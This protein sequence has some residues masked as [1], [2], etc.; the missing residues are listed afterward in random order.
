MTKKQLKGLLTRANRWYDWVRVHD[1][2]TLQE[3]KR[4]GVAASMTHR[5]SGLSFRHRRRQA[6]RLTTSQRLQPLPSPIF[7][8][9]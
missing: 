1:P 4:E 3:L 8:K 9:L 7:E 6:A 2:V 5:S